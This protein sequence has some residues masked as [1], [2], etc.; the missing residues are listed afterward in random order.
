MATDSSSNTGMC[1]FTVTVVDDDPPTITCPPTQIA[2]PGVVNYPPPTFADNCPGAMVVCNPPSGSNFPAGFTTVTC[3]ATDMAGNMAACSFLVS[4]FNVAIA[5]DS[6][7]G[8]AFINTST[9]DYQI[10]CGGMII[11]GKGTVTIKGCI[12]ALTHNGLDRRVTITYDT[13]KKEGKVVVQMPPGTPKCTIID[14]DT[15]NSPLAPCTP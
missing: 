1:S 9:G 11:S 14:S 4:T 3:T 2:P 13:C 10:C 8:S 7:G 5:G 6:G 15:R 12:V